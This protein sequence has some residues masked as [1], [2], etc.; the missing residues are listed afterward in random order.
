MKSLRQAYV[1]ERDRLRKSGAEGTD[2]KGK[3]PFFDEINEIMGCRP[4][5]S[6]KFHAS[7]TPPSQT[8]TPSPT[9]EQS[10]TGWMGTQTFNAFLHADD[11]RPEAGPS[12]GD[13]FVPE[14]SNPMTKQ[15]KYVSDFET[16]D[17]DEVGAQTADLWP[18][19]S[20][21]RTRSGKRVWSGTSDTDT[22]GAKTKR[23]KKV[24]WSLPQETHT[25]TDHDIQTDT[26]SIIPPTQPKQKHQNK[27]HCSKDPYPKPAMSPSATHQ[28]TTNHHQHPHP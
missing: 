3:C 9:E 11:N 23:K 28:K 21:I 4:I 25:D 5:A 7:S 8:L 27:N 24:S 1:N 10:I 26:H 2:S 17:G 20:P 22:E 13:D 16:T 15:N 19:D 14:G 12:S 6:P 18:S